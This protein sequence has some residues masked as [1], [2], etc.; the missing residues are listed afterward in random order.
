MGKPGGCVF[1]SMPFVNVRHALHDTLLAK[2]RMPPQTQ[3]MRFYQWRLTRA[4]LAGILAQH[5]F[6][7]DDVRAIHKREG[8][9][10]WLQQTFGFNPASKITKGIAVLLYPFVPKAVIGHMILAIARKPTA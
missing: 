7:V 2:W 4:E 5:G 6:A 9:Q 8:L 1:A 3:R 10:R